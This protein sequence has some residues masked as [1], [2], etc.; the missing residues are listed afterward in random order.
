M[1]LASFILLELP[2]RR[3]LRASTRLGCVEFILAAL[4][5][6]AH[7]QPVFLLHYRQPLPLLEPSW[8]PFYLSLMLFLDHISFF[9]LTAQQRPRFS[10][11]FQDFPYFPLQ[12]LSACHLILHPFC[13]LPEA[14]QASPSEEDSLQPPTLPSRSWLRSH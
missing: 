4:R 9:S 12:F 1:A 5:L 14:D 10:S 13:Y 7:L 2:R 11:S 8:P 3:L 6:L